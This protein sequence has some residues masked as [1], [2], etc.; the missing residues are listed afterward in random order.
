M[1]AA[2]GLP[3]LGGIVE[4]FVDLRRGAVKRDHRVPVVVHIQNE[5]LAHDGEANKGDICGWFHDQLQR[6]ASGV[7]SRTQ[8]TAAVKRGMLFQ[9]PISLI[10]C[11]RAGL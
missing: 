9:M 8:G 2:A 1:S 6:M 5:I 4:E 11:L 10:T 7:C 3:A